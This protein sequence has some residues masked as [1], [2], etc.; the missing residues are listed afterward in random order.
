M[1]INNNKSNQN[2]IIIK[3][4]K[5]KKPNKITL[6]DNS[7]ISENNESNKCNNEFDFKLYELLLFDKNAQII[8]NLSKIDFN[9]ENKIPLDNYSNIIKNI[10]KINENSKIKKKTTLHYYLM[11][12]ENINI[13]ILNIK[14]TDIYL[15]G[16]F[17]K[18]THSSIR[19][20]FLLHILL[21]FLNYM[22]EKSWYIK[23]DFE[24][25]RNGSKKS[26]NSE[27]K[28]INAY[29][30]K[31]SI[32]SSDN[33]NYLE[34]NENNDLL[35]SKI[36]EYFLLLPLI[37]FFV[38]ISKNIFI[39][40]NYYNKGAL[41]KNFYLV[42]LEAGQILFS[43][44]NI[45]GLN[46][47]EHPDRNILL[48]QLIFEELLYQGKFLKK[49]YIK[50]YGKILDFIDY[51]QF[52]IRLEFKSTHPKLIF[53]LRFLPLLNGILLIQEYEMKTYSIGNDDDEEED[54]KEIDILVGNS[55]T[56][57]EET[58]NE[59]EDDEALLINEP[60]FIKE[61]EYFFINFYLSTNSNINNIFYLK[62]SQIKY[63]SED[64][65]NIINKIINKNISESANINI[66]N[67]LLNINNELYNEYL[68]INYKKE[69]NPILISSKKVIYKKIKYNLNNET[70]IINLEL[71][72][73]D[74]TK[75]INQYQWNCSSLP[76]LKNLF[77]IEEKYILI[78]LFN[79]RNDIKN[80]QLTLDLSRLESYSL[81]DKE[82]IDNNNKIKNN[83]NNIISK[84]EKLSQLLNDELSQ[85]SESLYLDK[86]KNYYKDKKGMIK[87]VKTVNFSKNKNCEI[88]EE[89]KISDEEKSKDKMNILFD[90]DKSSIFNLDFTYISKN[91]IGLYDSFKIDKN[92]KINNNQLS[93]SSK[94]KSEENHKISI[95]HVNT[96]N[97]KKNPLNFNYINKKNN[98]D[99]NKIEAKEKD[100]D[101]TNVS[102]LPIQVYD[103][104]Y[105]E[106]DKKDLQKKFLDLYQDTIFSEEKYYKY[107]KNNKNTKEDN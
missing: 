61:R 10:I 74:N 41:Y 86:D 7:Y 43:L 29:S 70:D 45:Y 25:N 22:G 46:N 88:S 97:L 83:N 87:K 91:D 31:S 77:Q 47:G 33:N 18:S 66:E 26:I 44:E 14:N 9:T 23:R 8:F 3:K 58:E 79:Y 54:H 4:K 11:G 1:P 95:T 57:D 84:D 53:I 21:S 76:Y 37:K 81:L 5:K 49:D 51:Q 102:L 82:N 2:I 6:D 63:F 72:N 89:N 42:D 99:N 98:V 35:Y 32:I 55:I 60:K 27:K 94:K 92:N 107:E 39:R 19:K 65:L 40:H 68:Q 101:N 34:M 59:D 105:E 100:K 67:I 85:F 103:K 38:L 62:N 36:Y 90:N 20:I 71:L 12:N 52:Y 48:N 93:R 78:I 56:R 13:Q 96:L 17:D 50:K 80:N 104:S 16:A 75:I 28:I 30:N 15:L 24:I 64:V 69:K 106:K 73:E